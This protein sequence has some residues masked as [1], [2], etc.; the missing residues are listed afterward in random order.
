[1]GSLLDNGKSVPSLGQALREG[2]LWRWGLFDLHGYDYVND[3]SQLTLVYPIW[4]LIGR[5][6]DIR[7]NRQSHEVP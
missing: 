5:S 6:W 7:G 3:I 4:M 2:Y 1:M